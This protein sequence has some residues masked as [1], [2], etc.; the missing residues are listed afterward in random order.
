MT[1]T[2]KLLILLAFNLLALVVIF[3]PSIIGVT[4][5]EVEPKIDAAVARMKGALLT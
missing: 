3:V 5:E 1:R 4:A 2:K